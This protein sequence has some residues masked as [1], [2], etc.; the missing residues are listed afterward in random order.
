[1]TLSFRLFRI[2]DTIFTA[3]GSYSDETNDIDEG[4]IW[5]KKLQIL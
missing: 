1:M 5:Y 2:C 4:N 3:P